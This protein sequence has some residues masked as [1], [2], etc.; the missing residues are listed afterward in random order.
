MDIP[1]KYVDCQQPLGV[2]LIPKMP[3]ISDL[4]AYIRIFDSSQQ[5]RDIP[6]TYIKL[7]AYTVGL[8]QH[9]CTCSFLKV[10]N[11]LLYFNRNVPVQVNFSCKS[12]RC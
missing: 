7:Y 9:L 4:D 3:T 12:E 1:T 5:P 6:L 8:L 10:S 11:I 2:P